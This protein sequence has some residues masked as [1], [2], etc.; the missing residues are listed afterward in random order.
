MS[1]G[2]AKWF[3]TRQP[4]KSPG[5]EA[6]CG[7]RGCCPAM[8]FAMEGR[9]FAWNF[10]MWVQDGETGVWRISGRHRK[11]LAEHQ[12]MGGSWRSF[13]PVTRAIAERP[14]AIP[15]DRFEPYRP[16]PQMV[17]IPLPAVAE[18]P[19]CRRKWKVPLPPPSVA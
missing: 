18:C 14:D 4:G 7:V 1:I 19:V 6:R 3:P 2:E 16:L 9:D 11:A 12:R 17:A 8:F 15:P 13:R 10:G 5:Y